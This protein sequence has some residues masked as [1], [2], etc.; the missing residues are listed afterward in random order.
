MEP[1][2]L[3]TN[4]HRLIL[5]SL[6]ILSAAKTGLEKGKW[7]KK[8]LFEAGIEFLQSFADRFNHFKEEYLMFG[9]LAQKQEGAFDLEIGALR[10]QHERCRH[11]LDIIRDTL[12]VYS[13]GDE[14]AA[15]ALL[16]SLAAYTALLKRHIHHEDELFFPLIK[17]S[18]T[19]EEKKG[20][21]SYFEKE[22][23]RHRESGE[24]DSCLSSL[25]R[26]Q[27]PGDPSP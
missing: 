3:L 10:F 21:I 23:R 2:E 18:L 8:A 7:P 16:E 26:I 27:N 20:L 12:P 17:N 5:Q 13:E 4:E 24:L 22:E 11:H 14:M 9:I 1:T 25:Q 19:P 15:T 6:E